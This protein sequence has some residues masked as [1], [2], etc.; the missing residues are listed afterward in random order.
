MK[1]LLGFAIPWQPNTT[2]LDLELKSRW[3]LEEMYGV[4]VWSKLKLR[5]A[6]FWSFQNKKIKFLVGKFYFAPVVLVDYCGPR[7]L[8]VG[9]RS[10]AFWLAVGHKSWAWKYLIIYNK[11]GVCSRDENRGYFLATLMGCRLKSTLKG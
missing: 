3:V 5:E 9:L 10:F 6:I 8:T 7:V 11:H 1:S 4:V 2:T